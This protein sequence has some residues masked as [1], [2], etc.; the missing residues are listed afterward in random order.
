MKKS[1]KIIKMIAVAMTVILMLEQ[2]PLLNVL[3]AEDTD[4]TEVASDEIENEVDKDSGFAVEEENEDSDDYSEDS[5]SEDCAKESDDNNEDENVSDVGYESL[6]DDTEDDEEE[7]MDTDVDFYDNFDELDSGLTDAAEFE[8]DI[9]ALVLNELSE[10]NA[11]KEKSDVTVIYKEKTVYTT[12]SSDDCGYE[13]AVFPMEYLNVTNGEDGHGGRKAIDLGGKDSGIDNFYAPF[14][15]TVVKCGSEC[16]LDGNGVIIQSKNKVYLADGTVDYVVLWLAH[17]NDISDLYVGKEFSQGEIIYQEGEAGEA[18]GNH[19]HMVSGKGEYPKDGSSGLVKVSSG[20]TLKNEYSAYNIFWLTDKTKIINDYGYDWKYKEEKESIRVDNIEIEEDDICI[21][22]S[23]TFQLHAMLSPSDA[24]DQRLEWISSA[25][26]VAT[27]DENG[28]VTALSP[29]EATITV[30][31]LDGSGKSDSVIITVEETAQS[32]PVSTITLSHSSIDLVYGQAQT[33]TA[34]I[35]PDDA[36]NKTLVWTSDNESIVR[37]FG[38][39]ILIAGFVEGSAT[40]TAEA[41]D[42]SGIKAECIV[43]VTPAADV[44]EVS[45]Y[46]STIG[47]TDIRSYDA[48]LFADLSESV[49][50][51]EYGVYI[52]TESTI[53]ECEKIR[54]SSINAIDEIRFK[55][56]DVYDNITENTAYY[57]RFYIVLDGTEYYSTLGG[58]K[59]ISSANDPIEEPKETKYQRGDVINFG[60][61]FVSGSA[62]VPDYVN[63][64]LEGCIRGFYNV[65]D[66]TYWWNE[67]EALKTI[68]IRWIVLEDRGDSLLLISEYVLEGYS[69]D[70]NTNEDDVSWAESE[71]REYI[72]TGYIKTTFSADELNDILATPVVSEGIITSDKLFLP[73]YDELLEYFDNSSMRKASYYSDRTPDITTPISGWG[74]ALAYDEDNYTCAYWTRS[75][76]HSNYGWSQPTYVDCNGDFRWGGRVY[77][78]WKS[79]VRPMI[80]IDAS[81]EYISTALTVD[82]LPIAYEQECLVLETGEYEIAESSSWAELD[83]P[84]YYRWKVN[85]NNMTV[86]SPQ[87]VYFG[88]N[89]LEVT[90][91][92]ILPEAIKQQEYIIGIESPVSLRARKSGT[93]DE[94]QG[95]VLSWEKEIDK[96]NGGIGMF[97]VL[98]STSADGDYEQIYQG[99][100][101]SSSSKASANSTLYSCSYVD[102]TATPDVEYWYKVRQLFPEYVSWRTYNY[103][104][105]MH[106]Y[107]QECSQPVFVG[108]YMLGDVN[109]D[110]KVNAADRIYLARYLAGW[111]GYELSNEAAADVNKDNKVNAADRIYLARHLA[112]WSGYSLG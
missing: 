65:D 32:I 53:E 99:K 91:Y 39:G 51:D 92:G 62:F 27:V 33:I 31:S 12:S 37:V 68:P 67:Y 3:A 86:D 11:E 54:M 55:L 74:N 100:I 98:R 80:Q 21:G 8:D 95:I 101:N 6:T 45:D 46:F 25:I 36:S 4:T 112:G 109:N 110:G 41:A 85:G 58:F 56:S 78:T 71:I 106:G 59:T 69:F 50:V 108:N 7:K 72:N 19:V 18:H 75:S 76:N 16:G 29:G 96:R 9:P 88:E 35:A 83:Y 15:G 73:S 104:S 77:H 52:G 63:E 47:A 57:Y 17:D 97:E 10:T 84:I 89:T 111:S 13:Y 30:R 81:S 43:N 87:F 70:S 38:N 2:V 26:S 105:E 5:D 82:D 60:H 49:T 66:K 23:Q 20:W 48:V 107:E 64:Q 22:M 93:G 1:V 42:G 40:V 94:D 102:T 24:T 90:L 28:L 103:V 44:I 14:T 79:G 61:R 34:V